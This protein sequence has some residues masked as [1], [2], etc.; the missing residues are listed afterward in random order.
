MGPALLALVAGCVPAGEDGWVVVLDGRVVDEQDQPIGD[1][2]VR[3]STQDGAWIGDAATDANGAWRLPL[4][5]TRLTGNVVVADFDSADHAPGRATFE[6]ELRAPETAEVRAG[7][8]QTWETTG[9]TLATQRLAA[10]GDEG[11]VTVQV[12]DA[13]TGEVV[14]GV[15]LVAQ[16]G[17]N[18]PVGA[19]AGATATTDNDGEAELRL[20]PP[21]TWTIQVGAS[22]AWEGARFPA[23]ASAAGGVALGALSPPVAPG[24]L[25]AALTWGDRPYDLDLHLSA[26]LRGGQAGEDGNGRYHVWAGE[27]Q[28]PDRDVEGDGPEAAMERTASTGVGPETAAVYDAPGAGELRLSVVDND[29][30]SDGDSTALSGSRAVL[31]VWNGED[32]PRYYTISPG[33]TATWWQPMVLDTETAIVYAVERFASG[34]DP[35]DP[36]AF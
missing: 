15:D 27:P 26:P 34:V 35:A 11:I 16:W 2:G 30:L 23:F 25:R 22:D 13:R 8:W 4:F 14:P 19:A 10:G 31:Q 17:W 29:N 20:S 12:V 5:G 32:T 9:R 18:A 3:L 1:V 28:H 6:V 21:G 33:W 36:D 24:E 7:P